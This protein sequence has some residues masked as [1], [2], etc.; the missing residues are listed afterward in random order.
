MVI[1]RI[2]SWIDR[3]SRKRTAI[4]RA[5]QEFKTRTGR[6]S[7]WAYVLRMDEMSAIVGVAYDSGGRPAARTWF[8]VREAEIRELTFEDVADMEKPLS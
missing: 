6:H 2:R 3:R 1:T 7:V 5:V 8:E 4:A